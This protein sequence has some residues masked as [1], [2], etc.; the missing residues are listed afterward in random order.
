[1]EA[2]A[3]GSGE[4]VRGLQ[5]LE[6]LIRSWTSDVGMVNIKE[7]RFHM[8]SFLSGFFSSVL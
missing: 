3:G 5:P 2:S 8:V 4:K 6:K 1:M 7:S